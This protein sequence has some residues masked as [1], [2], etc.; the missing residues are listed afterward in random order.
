MD[1]HK[2]GNRRGLRFQTSKG[3]LSGEQLWGATMV[4]LSGAIKLVNNILKR[5]DEDYLSF[6][7][8][9]KV[10]DVENQLRFDILKDVY[11]TR[12][13]EMEAIR[14]EADKKAHNQKILNLISEKKEGDL[15]N[16]SVEE[17][18]KLIK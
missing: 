14:D 16:M 17:L 8:D 5:V 1:I 6:L 7:S 4:D 9:S 15:K 11:L 12:K 13:P 18:E 2:E 3:L 10:V